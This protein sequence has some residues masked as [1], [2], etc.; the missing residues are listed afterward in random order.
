MDIYLYHLYTPSRASSIYRIPDII[1]VVSYILGS[2]CWLWRN[3]YLERK[4]LEAM[5]SF[6]HP[7][8]VGS[9]IYRDSTLGI[10]LCEKKGVARTSRLTRFFYEPISSWLGLGSTEVP[11]V[12]PLACEHIASPCEQPSYDRLPMK[13]ML[14]GLSSDIG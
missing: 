11:R 2:L 4:G 14:T 10:Y 3:S 1:T 12:H 13:D 7:P 5:S 6:K 9:T 8:S